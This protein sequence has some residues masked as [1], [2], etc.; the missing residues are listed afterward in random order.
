[1]PTTE[2]QRR[3]SKKYDAENTR[4]I[5]MKLNTTTDADILDWL[6]SRPNKQGAIK[7]A[8]RER[9]NKKEKTA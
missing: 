6:D 7:E 8:I 4:Q 9:I 5:V 3:A 1:M 2:A